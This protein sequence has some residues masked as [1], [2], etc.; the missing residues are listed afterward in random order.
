MKRLLSFFFCAA[1]VWGCADAETVYTV[2]TDAGTY[3]APVEL[4]TLDVT[5]DDGTTVETNKFSE[6]Y[7]G[8]S[9]GSAVFRKRGGGW[10]MSSTNM[11]AFTGE[12]RV[13]EGAFMVKTNLMTGPLSKS[14]APTV[15][16]SNGASFVLAAK[17]TDIAQDKLNLY[18]SFQLDGEGVDGYGAIAPAGP[19]AGISFL[20][21]LESQ[22]R[23]P[24]L[25]T[26]RQ[27][28]R[29][30][31][32]QRCEHAGTYAYREQRSQ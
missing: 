17:A 4:D 13:E 11:A 7:G 19:K 20:R 9:A 6:V 28:V 10:M 15:V 31:L 22:R 24:S 25:R 30:R 1:A 2:T 29:S 18:N 14:T 16:V 26:V 27:S 21:L 3:D 5:V 8:F 32:G 12:I 23:H